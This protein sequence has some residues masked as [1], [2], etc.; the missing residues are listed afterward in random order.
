MAHLSPFLGRFI[1]RQG[2]ILDL[3]DLSIPLPLPTPTARPTSERS[4][5]TISTSAESTATTSTALS[6]STSAPVE[7]TT[8]P[9]TT[10]TSATSTTAPTPVIVVETAVSS[11]TNGN[12]STTLAPTTTGVSVVIKSETVTNPAA[13]TTSSLPGKT[14]ASSNSFL[15][16]KVA[17]GIVFGLCG[18]VGL[19]LI[20]LIV[21]FAMRKSRRIKQLEKEIISFDPEDVG[22][23]HQRRLDTDNASINSLEKGRRSGS[24]LG[25]YAGNGYAT[26]MNVDNG[27]YM[28][29]APFVDYRPQRAPTIQR[30]PTIQRAPTIQ[31]PGNA[32][33]N[34]TA[35][36]DTAYRTYAMPSQT[37]N[38]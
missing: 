22:R 23:F 19:V 1:R 31:R 4:T 20:F 2:G 10:T 37:Y 9:T 25:Q 5:E 8:A 11:N 6:T 26:T 29:T 3:P 14:G 16:N 12:T 33:F 18:L 15:E 34:P 36:S 27:D 30:G 17:S 13:Q 35:N 24:S 21:W 28:N 7:S 32:A 38:Q